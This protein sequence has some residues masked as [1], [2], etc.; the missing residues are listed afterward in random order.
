MDLQE[1]IREKEEV[2]QSRNRAFKLI[3]EELNTNRLQIAE[4]D[5]L[6]N[7]LRNSSALDKDGANSTSL[8]FTALKVRRVGMF[9]NRFNWFADNLHAILSK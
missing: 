5:A 6:I 9:N 8:D 2:I 7:Q 4:K 3:G 1:N